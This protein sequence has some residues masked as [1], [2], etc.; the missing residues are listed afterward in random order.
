MGSLSLQLKEEIKIMLIL[1]K[2]WPPLIKFL[3]KSKRYMGWVGEKQIVASFIVYLQSLVPS[4]Q[5]LKL[6]NVLIN[7]RLVTT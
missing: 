1:T 6:I 2:T 7:A 4:H 5:R 3:Y